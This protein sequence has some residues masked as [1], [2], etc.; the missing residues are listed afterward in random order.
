[1]RYVDEGRHGFKPAMLLLNAAGDRIAFVPMNRIGF[2][3]VYGVDDTAVCRAHRHHQAPHHD[4]SDPCQCGF[5]AYHERYNAPE[6]MNRPW[7]AYPRTESPVLLEVELL[8]RCVNGFTAHH[9][10]DF[11][12]ERQVVTA[13]HLADCCR[14]CR[15]PL[16]IMDP[17][18]LIFRIYGD[19]RDFGG[20]SYLQPVCREH[21]GP[22]ALTFD[23]LVRATGCPPLHWATDVPFWYDIEALPSDYCTHD[24]NL[25]DEE[26]EVIERLLERYGLGDDFDTLMAKAIRL[27]KA[28]LD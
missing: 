17:G 19:D 7:V 24:I 20:Y 4:P 28:L 12:A 2:E 6:Y 23:E 8:G 13:I 10:V 5:N 25:T 15:T 11:R 26:N 18:Y 16:G 22:R 9:E 27:S 1:M 14:I 21:A 3:H